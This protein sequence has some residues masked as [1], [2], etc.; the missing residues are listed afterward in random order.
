MHG[1]HG[2][3]SKWITGAVV[4]LSLAG[5]GNEQCTKYGEHL[6]DVVLKEA[7]AAGSPAAEDKRAELVKKTVEACNAEPP[8]QE[9]LDCALKADST[10]AMKKCEGVD[11]DAKKE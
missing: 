2:S 7:K 3:M 8:K 10:K 1:M 11:E 4:A 9:T 5:C 6:A